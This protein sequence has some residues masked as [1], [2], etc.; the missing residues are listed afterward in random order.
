MKIFL[1]W[2][3]KSKI[4]VIVNCNMKERGFNFLRFLVHLPIG[5]MDIHTK[6]INADIYSV[7]I[8]FYSD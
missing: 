3:N 7:R 8:N 2:S 6:R 1:K 4:N 5:Y